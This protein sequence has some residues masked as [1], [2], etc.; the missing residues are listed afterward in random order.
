MA[1]VSRMKTRFAVCHSRK[2]PADN[3]TDISEEGAPIPSKANK[4]IQT[5]LTLGTG[6]L[7]KQ[8]EHQLTQMLS[9]INAPF[10][11]IDHPEIQKLLSTLKP[12][13]KALD[14]RKASGPLL[15]DVYDAATAEAKK[16]TNESIGT[17]MIDAL[18]N[19]SNTPVKW[20]GN[21]LHWKNVNS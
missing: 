3:N 2:R 8:I 15:D 5:T 16:E 13:I 4:L 20:S 7:Q 19:I 18:S 11:S 6:A 1:L 14:R 17:L 10:G 9:A 12:D 21:C